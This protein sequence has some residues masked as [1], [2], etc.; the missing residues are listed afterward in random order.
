MYID[1]IKLFAKNEIELRT[2]IQTVG[3]YSQDIRM[4]FGREKCTTLVMLVS[5]KRQMT[6]WVELSNQIR[7]FGEKETYK[8][9][10]MLEADTIKQM[11]MKEK[12]YNIFISE[13]PE[14]YSRQN[15]TAGTVSKG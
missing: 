5:G 2:I 4:E 15:S 13:E 6:E 3:I 11:E 10:E 14:N 1:Y 8:Y 9:L 12:I 7:T